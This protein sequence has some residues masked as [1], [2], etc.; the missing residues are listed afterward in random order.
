[1]SNRKFEKLNCKIML[2]NLYNQSDRLLVL[3]QPSHKATVYNNA[4][5]VS[6]SMSPT[7]RQSQ[8]VN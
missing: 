2:L 5:F 4:D 8:V 3:T 1:M 7:D 6:W